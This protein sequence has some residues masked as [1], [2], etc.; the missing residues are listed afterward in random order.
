MIFFT[1]DDSC[2]RCTWRKQLLDWIEWHC[3]GRRI[4]MAK[5]SSS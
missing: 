4:P 5:W 3:N 2:N 1:Q